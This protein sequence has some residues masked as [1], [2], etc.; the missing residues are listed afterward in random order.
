MN[1][2]DV[3]KQTE[4]GTDNREGFQMIVLV[5]FVLVSGTDREEKRPSNWCGPVSGVLVGVSAGS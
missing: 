4:R 2:L 5:F 3:A 1:E